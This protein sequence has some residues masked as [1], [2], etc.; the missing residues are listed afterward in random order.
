MSG[1]AGRSALVTGA[2]RGVGRAIAATLAD[3]GFRVVCASRGGSDL[4]EAADRCGGEAVAA[5]LL[6]PDGPGRLAEEVRGLVGGDAP[7]VVVNNAGTFGLA[8]AHE[9]TPDLV[10]RHLSLNLRAPLLLTAS[11]L[12]GMLRRGRGHLLHVGSVAGRRPFP[13]NGAYA[14]SK[15]GLRGFHEVLREELAGTGVCSTLLELGAVDTDVWD[16]LSQR[17]GEDLPARA[18]MLS[19]GQAGEAALAA[20]GMG[21]FGRGGSPAVVGLNPE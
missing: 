14:A 18:E 6:R 9:L 5:D 16:P 10:D 3:A 2:S 21:P 11:F 19:P 20:V 12:P 1:F 7:D 13:E 4:R 8:P 15:Y 17:L